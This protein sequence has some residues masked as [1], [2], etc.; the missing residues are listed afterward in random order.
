MLPM[1]KGASTEML[2]LGKGGE[3]TASWGKNG[4]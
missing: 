2:L 1:N 4:I 3:G